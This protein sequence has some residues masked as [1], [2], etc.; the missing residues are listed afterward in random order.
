MGISGK[1]FAILSASVA[2]IV[3]AVYVKRAMIRSRR[4]RLRLV[5]SQIPNPL[6]DEELQDKKFSTLP[7]QTITQWHQQY[8]PLFEINTSEHKWVFVSDLEAIEAIFIKKSVETSL[9]SYSAW[10]SIVNGGCGSGI[11]FNGSEGKWKYLKAA[12]RDVLSPAFCDSFEGMSRMEIERCTRSL[13]TQTGNHG[14]VNPSLYVRFAVVNIVLYI[15]FGKPFAESMNDDTF[16]RIESVLQSYHKLA[17]TPTVAEG[18]GCPWS[19]FLKSNPSKSKESKLIYRRQVQPLI[20]LLVKSARTDNSHNIVKQLDRMREDYHMEEDDIHKIMEEF[21]FIS[22]RT[23]CASI[24][25]T[26]AL[27][28]HHPK[29]Q[30]NI[31]QEFIRFWKQNNYFPTFVDQSNFR[32]YTAFQK[33][34]FRYRPIFTFSAPRKVTK[35]V[36]YDG[37]IIPKDA[38]LLSSIHALHNDSAHYPEPE[39]FVPERFLYDTNP[40][41][42]TSR[43]CLRNRDH[44][45][46]GWGSRACPGVYMVEKLLFDVVIN[47]MSQCNVRPA[48]TVEGDKLYPDID[49]YIEAGVMAVPVD[50]KAR[51]IERDS[52]K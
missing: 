51:F 48:L 2:T 21:V 33:E 39:K 31:S 41:H 13:I 18:Q 42:K 23:L 22:C 8:G 49:N 37:L 20:Q 36:Y 29:A 27:L 35:D 4:R 44:F 30:T 26:Y 5:H 15:A 43:N 47:L 38:I 24:L 6:N 10:R 7:S 17:A 34:C 19:F 1:Y 25:W 45:A 40:M 28:C 46:F 3:A 16:K 14:S 32:Y 11:F 52:F 12:L 9:H 50:F